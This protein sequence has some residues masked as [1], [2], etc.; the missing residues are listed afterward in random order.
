MDRALKGLFEGEIQCREVDLVEVLPPSVSGQGI[1]ATHES[2][3][4]A[5]GA[6]GDGVGGDNELAFQDIIVTGTS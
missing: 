4:G 5:S 1:E 2:L 3:V 6:V